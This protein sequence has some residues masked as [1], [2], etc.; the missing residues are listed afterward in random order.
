MSKRR[1]SWIPAA[2][3]ALALA[4]LSAAALAWF[5][6]QG[7]LLYYGDAQAHLNIARRIFDSRTP[8]YE[9]I[10]TVWLPL[11]HVLMLPFVGND[12]W[13]RSGLAGGFP[14][15]VCFVLAGTFLFAAVRRWL[16]STPAA[17]AAAALFALNPNLLYLQ[18]TAMTEAV[19]FAALAALL[20][21]TVAY[22]DRPSWR[23]AAGAGLAA[24][25]ATLTRYEGWFLIPFVALYLLLCG[26]KS[27]LGKATLFGVL[28]GLGPLYW[29]AHNWW[30]YSNAL[31]FY[32][33]PYS[34]QAIYAR[35][36]ESG[37]Q[38]Y[39]GDGDWGKAL[40]YYS[41]AARLCLS[42]PLAGL[43]AAGAVVAL[44][45]RKIWPLFLLALPAF[46]YVMSMV[47]SGT[48]IFVPHLWPFSFYNTRYG[49][50][51][52]PMAALAAGAL[53]TAVPVRLR[54]AA[55]AVVVL[56]GISAWVAYPREQAWVCWKESQVNSDARRAWTRQAADYLAAHCRPGE[57]IIYSFG[58]LTAVF[59]QAGIPLKSGLHEGN[60]PDWDAAVA[61][62]EFFLR[63]P[64][65]MALSGDKLATA[66]LHAERR[67]LRY[68]L[69]KSITEKGAPVVEIYRREGYAYPVHE[70]ARR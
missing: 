25:A 8:G 63:E 40:R 12:A 66:L 42:W 44:V 5:L 43:A 15:A 6:A 31:E 21:C 67:G 64:W 35:A 32:N 48:P 27:R 2:G 33:G 24:L 23:A 28:A 51:A 68:R 39:P 57:G 4:A 26:K 29:L 18:S 54:T 70:G 11:P 60:R 34:A 9:Q 49:L 52:L 53:V 13:W 14:S 69:E 58:D 7:C 65:A 59:A 50:A 19:L 37:M 10:G 1:Q 38:R 16:D 61:R 62:P 22:R 46:F 47:S 20:Y 56:I 3:V 55:A 45:R 41:E 17:L 30:G 36:L